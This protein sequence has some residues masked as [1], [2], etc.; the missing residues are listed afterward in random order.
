MI[1]LFSDLGLEKL[2]E[3][4]LNK[5]LFA[6]DFDGTLAP[7][8][9]QHDQVKLPPKTNVLL[10][11]LSKKTHVAVISGRSLPN[12][13][14][15]IDLPN[16]YLIG[17]HGLESLD[18]STDAKTFYAGICQNWKEQIL[19]SNNKLFIEDKIYSLTIH[20]R[21]IPNKKQTRQQILHLIDQLSPLPR[22]IM[23]KCVVNLLP[24]KASHKGSALLQILAKLDLTTALYLGDDDT[25]EDIFLLPQDKVISVRIGHKKSS[26]AQFYLKRQNEINRLITFLNEELFKY[27]NHN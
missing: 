3:I 21:D 16:G 26:H 1:Y 12:L 11:E 6:F 27:S 13:Q 17:N 8:K 24:D 23:G 9:P 22:V 25:D 4:S 10:N 20:Y 14:Q 5:T 18:I 19:L 7:I 2:K 15:L